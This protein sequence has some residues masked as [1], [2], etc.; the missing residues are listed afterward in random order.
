MDV[1]VGVDA[2]EPV[3]NHGA[4]GVVELG[5]K[6]GPGRP[7]ADDGDIELARRDR[8]GLGLGADEG[9]DQFAV[10]AG[11][12]IRRLQRHGEPRRPWRAEIVGHAA[13]GDHQIIIGND[14]G[15]GDLL[16]LLVEHGPERHFAPRPVEPDHRAEAE[17]EMMPVGEQEVIHLML[18]AVETARRHRMQERLPEMGPLAVDQGDA[19]EPL[20][21]QRVA[22]PA[23][24]FESA[25]AAPH[26][27]DVGHVLGR[28]GSIAH[29]RAV[30]FGFIARSFQQKEGAHGSG[31]LARTSASPVKRLIPG[32]ESK[33]KREEDRSA[34][35]SGPHLFRRVFPFPRN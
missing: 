33:V 8:P 12:L 30:R 13:D 32:D 5:G 26:D 29:R 35:I 11:R 23:G 4:G 14:R 6:L 17:T 31:F 28:R 20:P 22:K 19:G 1:T 21:P 2:V 25:R 10:E 3:G 27:D 16:P 9:V 7:G 24:E 15:G 34:S 18:G